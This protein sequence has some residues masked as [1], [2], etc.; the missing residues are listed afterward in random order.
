VICE[1]IGKPGEPGTGGGIEAFSV[2]VSYVCDKATTVVL[3]NLTSPDWADAAPEMRLVAGFSER[4]KKPFYHLVISFH[5]SEQPTDTQMVAAMEHMLETLGL[6]EH[7]AVIGTHNGS[8]Q[9]HVHA[10]V[11]TVNP[12]TAITWSKSGDRAKAELA[13]RQIELDQGWKREHGRFDVT[14]EDVEGRQIARL[15]PKPAE[16]WAAKRTAREAG[17]RPKTAGQIK[18]EKRTGFQ[19]LDN[20]LPDALRDRFADTVAAVDNWPDLHV[21]LG[22]MGLR[23]YR[24][25]SGARVEIFGAAAG[26]Y[27][28]ASSFGARFSIRAMESRLGPYAD[29]ETEYCNDLKP[30]HEAN[31]MLEG[32]PA[33]EHAKATRSQSFKT[34]IL[35]RMY[36]G[37]HLDPRVVSAIRFVDL[38]D[39]P[40]QISFWDG[41]TV[42]DHGSRLTSSASIHETRATMI[43]M[44]IAK[45]WSTVKPSGSEEFLRSFALEAAQ[46]GLQVTG[47]PKAVQVLADECLAQREKHQR[48]IAQE[49]QEVRIA[50]LN[51]V[52]AREEAVAMN[53]GV[54]AQI[55]AYKSEIRTAAEAVLTKLGR[56]RDPTK[57]AARAAVHLERDRLI[58]A[59]PDA[60]RVPHPQGAP[61]MSTHARS[62][63][64]RQENDA[65][66]IESMKRLDIGIIA[67][68]GGWSDVSRTHQDTSDKAGKV[69]RIY[70]RGED[71]VKAS[72]VDGKWLW[73]SNKTGRQGSVIDL[74]QQ[75]NPRK[76][77]GDARV[78]L[79]ALS[80]ML[81]APASDQSAFRPAREQD[82]TDARQRW[83]GVGDIATGP[84]YAEARG[85]ERS[86]LIR[87]RTEI[88]AGVFEGVYFA[89]RDLGTGDV[90]GFEQRWEKDGLKNKARFAKG[91]RKS[92]NILG[93]PATVTRM[94]FVEGGLDALALAEIE[95]RDDTLY[96]STGGGFG[97]ITEAALIELGKGHEVWS[98]FDNDEAGN[99]MDK[100]LRALLA[101]AYRL[102]PPAPIKGRQ[103]SC[104]DWLDVLVAEKS[105]SAPEETQAGAEP[106]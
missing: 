32:W 101:H 25:G 27:A 75:D 5:E 19:V 47:V 7:Q 42:V 69:Y 86:T 97:Q 99:A 22:R 31:A 81:P 45:G 67:S 30:P 39:P 52:T 82:H 91:G 90:Q 79:R 34:T 55:T 23:Y 12:V 106:S 100:K 33:P 38:A 70:Q 83:E 46:V 50:H 1:I 93:N 58:Q 94:K 62:K 85:I 20:V 6:E 105:G 61:D 64:H 3:R 17:R 63:N 18:T 28:K 11:N 71:T 14:V 40:P 59:L 78:A 98:A 29:P 54:R 74:W 84:S 72:L 104:K 41:S 9:K 4:V 2:G 77:L 60:R 48:R 65:T 68:A 13:C 51:A 96:V 24:S 43:A 49:A 21:A 80:G 10:V 95:E 44:A 15:V 35:G 76:T 66:E 26:S 16:H 57:A 87:F 88:R 37:I 102:A 89:H 36:A 53:A 103:G 56:E 8:S 73:T 92:V